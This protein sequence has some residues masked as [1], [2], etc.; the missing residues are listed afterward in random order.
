M[1]IIY[2]HIARRKTLYKVEDPEERF[3]SGYL[4][5]S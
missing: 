3:S 2:T 1:H 4:G 5:V